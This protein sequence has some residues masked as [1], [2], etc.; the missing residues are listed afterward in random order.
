MFSPAAT[1]AEAETQPRPTTRKG[2]ALKT[3]GSGAAGRGVSYVAPTGIV[4]S[5]SAPAATPPSSVGWVSSSS[6]LMNITAV[7]ED[8]APF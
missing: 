8:G 3:N 4:G 5:G 2:M 7:E 6:E 1:A